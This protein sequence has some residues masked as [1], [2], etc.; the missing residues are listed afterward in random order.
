MPFCSTNTLG[1]LEKSTLFMSTFHVPSK[2]LCAVAS[3]GRNRAADAIRK[4]SFFI[5]NLHRFDLRSKIISESALTINLSF[6]LRPPI[7][8]TVLTL[9]Q[10][11]TDIPG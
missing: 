4:S 7:F 3:V 1:F 5:A 9:S 10:A 2:T 8:G 6:V 11:V